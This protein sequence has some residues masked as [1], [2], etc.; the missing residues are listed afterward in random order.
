MLDKGTFGGTPAAHKLVEILN[1][2]PNLPSGKVNV[3]FSGF[4]KTLNELILINDSRVR[5]YLSNMVFL[6]TRN[7]ISHYPDEI[8]TYMGNI[9]TAKYRV[10]LKTQNSQTPYK[11]RGKKWKIE[12]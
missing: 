9:I 3:L 2:N 7:R 6:E 4:N 10:W 12:Y 11:F 8:K 5:F 1:D